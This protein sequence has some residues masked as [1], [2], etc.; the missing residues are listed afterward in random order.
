[1]LPNL[2]SAPISVTAIPVPRLAQVA[3][4]S[5]GYLPAFIIAHQNAPDGPMSSAVMLELLARS[6]RP[7]SEWVEELPKYTVVKLKVATPQALKAMVVESARKTLGAE[8]EK[9]VTI[10]GVK[11]FFSDGWILIRPSGTEP[12]VRVY[13]EA[14]TPEL[15]KRLSSRGTQLVESV[16]QERGVEPPPARASG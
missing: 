9:L 14:R 15:A 1:V 13:A 2:A 3:P 12:L 8:A 7:L 16:L 5:T 6:D 4:E 10:D 11:A